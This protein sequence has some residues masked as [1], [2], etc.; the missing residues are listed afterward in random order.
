MYTEKAL[1]I[2]AN[3]QLSLYVLYI[4]VARLRGGGGG[5]NIVNVM[6]I[7][8]L[9]LSEF[10]WSQTMLLIHDGELLQCIVTKENIH[11]LRYFTFCLNFV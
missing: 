2:E 11:I 3:R 6:T 10:P 9:Y 8:I 4:G 1:I 5:C 7:T